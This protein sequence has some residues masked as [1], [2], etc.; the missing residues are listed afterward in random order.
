MEYDN[1]AAQ[2]GTAKSPGKE[3][4]QPGQHGAAARHVQ[5]NITPSTTMLAVIAVLAK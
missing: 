3:T 2:Q 4:M 1:Y 5:R